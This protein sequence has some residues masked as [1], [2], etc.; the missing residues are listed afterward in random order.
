[1][2]VA[3]DLVRAHLA[4]EDR[5]DVEAA[6][7][8]FGAAPRYEIPAA[9]VDL[10]GRAAVAGHHAAMLAAFPD[11]ANAGVELYDA[12]ARVFARLRVERTHLG[13]WNGLAPTGRRIV[14]AALAEF[15][16][17]D[18]DLLAG[19]IVHLDPLDA[20]H[21]LGAL[22]TRDPFALARLVAR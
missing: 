7:A 13:D 1:M 8:C 22:P 4:A 12:G 5:G 6:M 16:L 18:D 15:P 9:G 2:A 20:L 3:V 21:Q 11:F 19:E 17:G 10:R 14:T